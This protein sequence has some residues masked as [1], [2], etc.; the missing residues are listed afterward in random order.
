MSSTGAAGWTTSTATAATV[1][2]Y[3]SAAHSTA[4]ARDVIEDFD[5]GDRIDLSAID[6]STTVA[7]ND[8]FAFIGSGAFTDP[9]QLRATDTGGGNWLVEGD[10]DG[11][12]VAD[13]AILVH[14]TDGHGIGAGDF[15]L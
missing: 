15:V 10:I 9:G 2:G 3:V 14:V 4:A 8:A 12:G 6:A 1:F 7:G 11:D 5:F 13:L